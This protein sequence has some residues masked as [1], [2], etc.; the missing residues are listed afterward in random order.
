MLNVKF[1]R[2]FFMDS[3]NIVDVATILLSFVTIIMWVVKVS[4]RASEVTFF[5][6][7]LH[8]PFEGFAVVGRLT[9]NCS[10][11]SLS[12]SHPCSVS[13]PPQ[14][15]PF[16]HPPASLS[17]HT[18]KESSII[19]DL[20]FALVAPLHSSLWFLR[21]NS[22]T[23]FLIKVSGHKLESSQTRFFSTLIFRSKQ[24]YSWI[25][26]SFADF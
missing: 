13:F 25:D 17:A 22:E 15:T 18:H 12:L 14:H 11:P 7:Y 21:W 23:T 16:T 26:S 1:C 2:D 6:S 10:V 24:F 20:F 4:T 8:F 5:W 3:W 9:I 19:G